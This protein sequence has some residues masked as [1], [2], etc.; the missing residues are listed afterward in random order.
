M[1]S[2]SASVIRN[3]IQEARG[4]ERVKEEEREIQAENKKYIKY[5]ENDT[6]LQCMEIE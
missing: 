3:R 6:R 1:Y 4:R 2:T 5:E